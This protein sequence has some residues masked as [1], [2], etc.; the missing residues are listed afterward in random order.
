[1]L[2]YFDITELKQR[3]REA[4]EAE[5]AIAAA[6]A[7]INHIL[8]SSSA[9][10]YS[11]KASGDY[12]PTF[13]SEN[14]RE[15]FGYEPSEYLED[16][17][18]M[19][20]RIHPDD[21]AR[22]ERQLL[23]L[24]EKGYLSNEYR[25]RLKDGRYFW[26]RDELKVSYD[27]AGKPVEV[28]G[29]WTDITERK[30]AETALHKHTSY[31][32]LLKKIAVA[33]NEASAIED[34]LQICL[35]EVCSNTGWPVGHAYMLAGDGSGELFS[36][37]LWHL[38]EPE[39]F[40]TFKKVTEECRFA[41][42]I[43]LPGRV[44]LSGKPEWIIDVTKD[45]NFP[46]AKLV[47]NIGVKNAFCFPILVGDKVAAILE[48]FTS[49]FIEPDEQF[50]IIMAQVSTQLGQVI[51]RKQAEEALAIAKEK[52]EAA[53]QAK[54]TFV[55]TISH[56]FRTPLNAVIG[57]TEMLIEDIKAQDNKALDEPL[58]RVHRAGK[59]LLSLINE[60]LDI[61]KIEAGKI[62]LNIKL[63]NITELIKDITA[64]VKPM[65]DSN[66]NSLEVKNLTEQEAMLSDEKRVTQILLNLLSNAAK[67]TEKGSVI[68]KIKSSIVDKTDYIFFD[69][70]DTGT[71]I[72]EDKIDSV[73]DEYSQVKSSG[74]SK[75]ASTGLGLGISR[76]LAR[77]LGGDITVSSRYGEGS[78]FTAKLPVEV[79]GE[80]MQSHKLV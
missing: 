18:F 34:V 27:G 14:V 16:R 9:V 46:R 45:T 5:A 61:S 12:A 2:T 57:I 41:P 10:L 50:L 80:A 69:V 77:V 43:G 59:H 51:G 35:D 17:N 48:F 20:D 74:S 24:F 64:T 47:E 15:L 22:I 65:F 44:L 76:K 62:D 60:I 33:A 29:A 56:E 31:L 23:Q 63:F 70:I 7:R 66:N 72:P 28:V 37:K 8:A 26:V 11:F 75:Y 52:A 67:F 21:A 6:H 19:P 54:T 30:K 42:G 49:K 36:T 4:K 3:E 79:K 71:G 58:T 73:F 38:D 25:F 39:E 32:Q 78:T 1:M 40:K 55:S 13:I 53:N 68:L